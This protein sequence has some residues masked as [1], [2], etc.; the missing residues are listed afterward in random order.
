M[1]D[2]TRI[3]LFFNSMKNCAETS[4][5]FYPFAL[6][7]ELS[8][9]VVVVVHVVG[10]RGATVVYLA[11]LLYYDLDFRMSILEIFCWR[12]GQQHVLLA[13]AHSSHHFVFA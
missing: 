12:S 6:F 5:Y 13:N 9:Q 8:T 2:D 4:C 1:D 3:A 10:T 7:V 11:A